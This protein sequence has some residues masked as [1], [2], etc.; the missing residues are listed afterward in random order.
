MRHQFEI[1]MVGEFVSQQAVPEVADDPKHVAEDG[2][3][4]L[5]GQVNPHSIGRRRV[6][7]GRLDHQIN[8]QLAHPKLGHGDQSHHHSLNHAREGQQ[9]ANFPNNSQQRGDVSQSA[10]AIG[11]GGRRVVPPMGAHKYSMAGVSPKELARTTELGPASSVR[12]SSNLEGRSA[13]VQA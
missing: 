4:D 1:D 10:D 8:N 5:D 6:V 7:V 11:P 12:V 2:E 3:A 13:S 9:G